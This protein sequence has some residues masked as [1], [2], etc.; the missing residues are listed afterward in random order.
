MAPPG[1][2]LVW[3]YL[4]GRGAGKTRSGAEWIRE[5]LQAGCGRLALIAP[6]AGDARDVM[7]EGV[8]GI[9]SVCWEGDRTD[10]GEVLGIPAYEPS[11][12]RLTW[13]NGAQAAIFSAEEPERLRG[14]QHDALWADELAAWADPQATWDMA[15][16]GLRLGANPQAMVT[17]TP[18][19]LPI[20]RELV[21]DPRNVLTRGSTWDNRTHLAESFFHHVV[22]KYEGT[23]LGRQELNAEILEEADGA[24]WRRDMIRRGDVPELVR[25]VVGVDPP[26]S[27]S[28]D[29]A[30]AGIVVCGLG[31]DRRG[32]VLA[33]YS[34][35]MSPGEWGR[36]VVA[37]YDNFNADRIIAEGNQGG[38]MV[39][40]TIQTVRENI[41]VT[42]VHASRGK[43][44][45]A[46]PVAALYE[47]GKVDHV[48]S[49]PALEDE[50]CTWEPLSALPSPD[51]LD[52]MVW[53]MTDLAIGGGPMVYA[54]PVEQFVC[55]PIRIP[56][57]WPQVCVLDIDRTHFASVWGAWHRTTDTLYLTNEYRAP[58]SHLAVHVAAVK[59]RGS[60][61]PAI[62]DIEDHGR[63]HDAGWRLVQRLADFGL[64]LLVV[65]LDP[66]A[67]IAEIATRLTTGQLKV[68]SDLPIWLSQYRQFRRDEKLEL[69]ERDAHLMRATALMVLAGTDAGI[70]ENRAASGAE[71]NTWEDFGLSG[72]SS[73]TGY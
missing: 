30:L 60:W 42:I 58:L 37:A 66:E 72:R 38:E 57:T 25:V 63:T 9:M 28:G 49:F 73:S 59:E 3:T 53:A 35:R 17:T 31:I 8:S 47:Q 22:G 21:N 29:S 48:G 23:R 2:W 69:V 56:S 65:P 46:E 45:R 12:R 55:D 32:Y 33:D 13:A 11:K 64:D 41:P 16:F 50:M 24:L 43:Q 10:K 26:A 20:I 34:G 14:P 67:G 52:A 62:V 36:K 68:F 4:A 7:V 61:I 1:N 27:S 70:T 71:E 44:A 40:H 19:P 6:T 18:K 5:K 51:R 39:R 54:L 15:M